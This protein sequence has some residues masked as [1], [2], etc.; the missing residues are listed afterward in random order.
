MGRH[1]KRRIYCD[2]NHGKVIEVKSA[3]NELGIIFTVEKFNSIEVCQFEVICFTATAKEMKKVKRMISLTT[4][5]CCY[6]C[7]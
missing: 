2:T 7:D 4:D 3:L 1:V 6:S 5:L